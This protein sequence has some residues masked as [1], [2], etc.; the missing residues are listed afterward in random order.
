MLGIETWPKRLRA[1]TP[2]TPEFDSVAIF[3]YGSDMM[4]LLIGAFMGAILLPAGSIIAQEKAKPITFKVSAQTFTKPA[5]WVEQK[6][7]SRMRAAQFGV[8]GKH[9]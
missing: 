6:T 9:G 7:A 4:K 3:S 2:A 5:K 1:G 8:S